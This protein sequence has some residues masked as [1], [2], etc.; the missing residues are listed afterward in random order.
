MDSLSTL[1][2]STFDSLVIKNSQHFLSDENFRNRT[3]MQFREEQGL[4]VRFTELRDILK[5][6]PKTTALEIA[7]LMKK[8]NEEE[9]ISENIS[10]RIKEFM[11]WP[12]K[13]K[14]L[15]NDL[16]NYGAI[17]D[18]RMGL[19]NGIDYGASTYSGE[20]FA[21]AVLFDELQVAFW[22]HMSSNLIHQDFQ[23]RLIWDPALREATIHEIQKNKYP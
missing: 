16:N 9:L 20:P 10:K 19:V 4:G 2:R 13:I 15:Q 7:T 17:Y 1:S 5:F 14:R 8:I 23:Q 18:S 3:L 6:F 11:D 22:F 21:Q 12:M